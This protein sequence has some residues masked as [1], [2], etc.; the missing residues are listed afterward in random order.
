MCPKPNTFFILDI[1]SEI[2]LVIIVLITK[3]LQLE[4]VILQVENLI[5]WGKPTSLE[6]LRPHI[7]RIRQN[8]WNRRVDG[9]GLRCDRN[10]IVT[11]RCMLMDL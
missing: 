8:G 11:T 10:S 2:Y 5:L 3:K 9:I 1:P 4:V 7:F 6:G